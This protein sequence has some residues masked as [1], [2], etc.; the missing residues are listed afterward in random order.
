MCRPRLDADMQHYDFVDASE[1]TRVSIG[2][3]RLEP[4][5]AGSSDRDQTCALPEGSPNLI[6]R[7]S[8]GGS[9]TSFL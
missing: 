9:E 5:P 2:L 1:K 6:F 8:A 7:A 4:A 3:L